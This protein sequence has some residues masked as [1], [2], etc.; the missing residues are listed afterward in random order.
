IK[1]TEGIINEVRFKYKIEKPIYIAFDE[2]NVWY[3]TGGEERLEE[4]YDLQ[5]V[6]AVATFLNSLIRNA[7]VVKMAN[8]AQLVNVIAPMMITDG[9]LW[10]QTTYYPLQ[11]FATNCYGESVNTYVQ[12]DTFNVAKYKGVQWLDVS[13]AY[14]AKNQTLI[15]NVVNR[16]PAKAIET[17]IESQFGTPDKKGTAFEINSPG[18]KDENSVNEQKV[19]TVEKSFSIAGKNF[20]YTFPAHSFTQLVIKVK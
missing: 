13:S 17:N 14:N 1:Q 20:V 9:K 15:V 5:D 18:L 16:H 19:K 11:L 10:K 12:S 3:R 6:L 2:Y 8:I 7:H 4:K